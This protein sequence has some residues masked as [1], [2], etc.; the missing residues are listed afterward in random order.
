[1]PPLPDRANRVLRVAG[2]TLA[3]VAIAGIWA[4]MIAVAVFGVR[5]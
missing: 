5:P 4:M 2:W 1:M 3:G